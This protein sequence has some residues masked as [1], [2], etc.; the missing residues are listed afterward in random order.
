MF[1][2]KTVLAAHDDFILRVFDI[3]SGKTIRCKVD[4]KTSKR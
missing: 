2:N 1:D 3:E 4:I